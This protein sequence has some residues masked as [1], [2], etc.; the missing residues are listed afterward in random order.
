[1]SEIN[2]FID[3]QKIIYELKP[4]KQRRIPDIPDGCKEGKPL[5][6]SEYEKVGEVPFV[7][8]LGGKEPL[9]NV[10]IR[11]ELYKKNWA[12]QMHAIDS[13]LSKTDRFKFRSLRD[14]LSRKDRSSDQND[15]LTTALLN[16]GS[17][18]SNHDRLLNNVCRYLRED[19]NVC[20]VKINPNVCF[21]IQRIIKRIE[22]TL[23][24]KVHDIVSDNLSNLRNKS[25][26]KVSPRKRARKAEVAT[27]RR[28]KRRQVESGS[29]VSDAIKIEDGDDDHAAI[30]NNYDDDIDDEDYKS[31]EDD[32]NGDENEEGEEQVEEEEEEEEG[33]EESDDDFNIELNNDFDLL[34]KKIEKDK[35]VDIEDMLQVFEK[36]GVRLIV[37]VQNAD[38]MN[39]I[40]IQQTLMLLHRYNQISDVY[41][42]IGIST[43]FIIFQEKVPKLLIG[44]LRTRSFAVDNSNEAINQIMEDLLLNINETYNSLIFDPK[45]VLKFLYRRDVMS[46]QQFNNYMKLIYMRHY[47]SQPLSLFWTNDFSKIDLNSIYFKIFKTLPS[48]MENSSELDKKHLVGIVENDVQVIGDLLRTNLN[49]LINWRFNF[50][51]L[52]DFLNFAQASILDVKIW[53]NNLELFQLLFEKYYELRDAKEVWNDY[54]EIDEQESDDEDE[55]KRKRKKKRSK[56]SISKINPTSLFKFLIE[57]WDRLRDFPYEKVES[58]YNQLCSDEQFN[59]ITKTERFPQKCPIKGAINGF[60]E[61]IQLALRD[62]VC[63][64]DLDG[65]AFREICVVREDAV[66]KIHDGFEPCVRENC[67]QNLDEPGKVLFNSRHWVLNEQNEMQKTDVKMFSVIEPI[68]CEMYRIF[69]ETGLVM[70]VYDF[71]QV[72]KNSIVSRQELIML[73][74]KKVVSGKYVRSL[75]GEKFEKLIEILDRIEVELEGG[76]VEEEWDKMLLSWFLK[77]VSEFQML[78]LLKEGKSKSQSVEKALWRGI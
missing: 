63:E 43:P 33:E 73:M 42:I 21:N 67:L 62:Q 61:V 45:L 14:F 23:A 13:V 31:D 7:R 38:A 64:L 40:L 77:S 1:M 6:D 37:L 18:I 65:Q 54:S 2:D 16:L 3:S 8:L 11:H 71:Y 24:C 59:F 76:E 41:S 78:G 39:S 60:I 28:R 68:L 56:Y 46:I 19:E 36:A 44:K 51:N 15:L 20:L 55:K 12:R 32:S 53:S 30:L 35:Y 17:N 74:R 29:G 9:R 47:Y 10:K 58:F 57:M 49:Q 50:R 27:P 25:K 48:V 69:K 75:R 70:N 5:S 26:D 34:P 4:S 52:I 22:D 72:F 66:S